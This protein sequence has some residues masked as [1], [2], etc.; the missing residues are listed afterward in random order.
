MIITH[1]SAGHW[2]ECGRYVSD[3]FLCG[4]IGCYGSADAMAVNCPK[5][6]ALLRIK[7]CA[8]NDGGRDGES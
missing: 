4:A 5:C 8:A 6:L 7:L 1:K 3:G 2:D